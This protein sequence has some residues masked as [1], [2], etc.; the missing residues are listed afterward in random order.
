MV[1]ERSTSTSPGP[2]YAPDLRFD[3][4]P[5]VL[6]PSAIEAASEAG[7]CGLSLREAHPYLSVYPVNSSAGFSPWVC[8]TKLGEFLLMVATGYEQLSIRR[9][10]AITQCIYGR[11]FSSL[12]RK[13]LAPR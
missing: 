11:F 7:V 9:V 8:A 4:V 6:R 1:I 2:S 5:H 12:K 13:S 10:F 3:P